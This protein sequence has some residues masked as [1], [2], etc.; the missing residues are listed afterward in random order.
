MHRHTTVPT[1]GSAG[2]Q[3]STSEH[4]SQSLFHNTMALPQAPPPKG[5]VRLSWAGQM[6]YGMVWYEVTQ[7]IQARNMEAET[8]SWEV[9]LKT[10]GTGYDPSLSK[11]ALNSCMH[12]E[13]LLKSTEKGGSKFPENAGG[14]R[15]AGFNSPTC[16][17]DPSWIHSLQAT[18]QWHLSLSLPPSW[19]PPFLPTLLQILQFLGK[20]H[21]EMRHA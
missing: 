18:H 15:L 11:P 8:C 19:L 17:K 12:S 13:Y 4:S 2:Y 9:S 20:I 7:L 14:C 21:L 3:Q 16:Q 1:A 6:G 10:R 5:C